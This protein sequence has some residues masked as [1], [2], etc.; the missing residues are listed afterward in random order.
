MSAEHTELDI[1]GL[2]FINV[3]TYKMSSNCSTTWLVLGQHLN[4]LQRLHD[5]Q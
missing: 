2:M 1:F 4:L 3:I 5:D